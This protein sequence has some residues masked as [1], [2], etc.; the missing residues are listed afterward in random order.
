MAD[1][2]CEF[3]SWIDIPRDQVEN[4]SKI[5]D[6]MENIITKENEFVM[7]STFMEVDENRCGVWFSNDDGYGNPDHVEKIARALIEEL[8][9]DDL[10]VCSW[11]CTCS[12]P[13]IDDFGGGAFGIMRGRETYWVDA[14]RKVVEDMKMNPPPC[15]SD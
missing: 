1:Y 7:C 15:I 10:F 4:A 13:R 3:S 12:K 9:L 6:K 2:Y 5:I 11:S 14:A 8:K